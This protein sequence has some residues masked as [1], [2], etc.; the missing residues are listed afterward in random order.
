MPLTDSFTKLLIRGLLAGLIAGILAGGV[1]FVLGESHIDAAIAIEES[2]SAAEPEGHSHDAA[3]QRTSLPGTRTT[4][5]THWSA[6]TGSASDC[7]SPRPSPDW[8]SE[9]SSPSSR[10]TH[11]G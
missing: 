4:R 8:L 11:V 1:A 10:I 9:R 3:T 2:H 7:S 6:A 5:K